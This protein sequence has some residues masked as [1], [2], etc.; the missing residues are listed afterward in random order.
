MDKAD[1]DVLRNIADHGDRSLQTTA[2]PHFKNSHKHGFYSRHDA[3]S[4]QVCHRIFGESLQAA[5]RCIGH[6]QQAG[7][8][9]L[10]HDLTGFGD[11]TGVTG[12]LCSGFNHVQIFVCVITN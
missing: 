4:T 9:S 11:N 2:Q 12:Y 5:V 6:A 8:S 3:K 10:I 7:I 1:N